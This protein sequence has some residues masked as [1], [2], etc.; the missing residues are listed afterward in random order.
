MI[1]AFLTRNNNLLQ[2]TRVKPETD[3]FA[4]QAGINGD[5][6]RPIDIPIPIG[7]K[8]SIKFHSIGTS[9]GNTIAAQSGPLRILDFGLVVDIK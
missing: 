5:Q 8:Q 7:R 6:T 4:Q 9:N 3:G 2:S 1:A